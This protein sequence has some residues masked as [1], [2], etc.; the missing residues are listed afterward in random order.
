MKANERLIRDF[1]AV[2][3]RDWDAVRDMLTADVT[4]HEPLEEDFSGDHR[5]VETVT[6]LLQKLVAVTSGSFTL[7]PTDFI[8]TAEHVATHVRWSAERD[9]RRV[10]GNDL[11]VFRIADGKI[12]A[13]W[14]FPDGFDPA[15][16]TEV[17]SFGEG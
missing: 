4:W 13:A 11:A 7:E 2:R 3:A 5:G 6:A 10:Q 8:V 1:Y 12:A 15:A 17:F 14:F 16:M 9:G